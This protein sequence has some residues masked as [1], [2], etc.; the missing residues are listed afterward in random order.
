[1]KLRRYIFVDYYN[2]KLRH[3][4]RL[5]RHYVT[6]WSASVIIMNG[7]IIVFHR[8]YNRV[9]IHI[10]NR[11]RRWLWSVYT[12][13]PSTQCTYNRYSTDINIIDLIIICTYLCIIMTWKNYQ[14]YIYYHVIYIYLLWMFKIFF[15]ISRYVYL[16]LYTWRN[17][18][19]GRLDRKIYIHENKP[20]GQCLWC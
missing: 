16:Y 19:E 1:M 6:W 2:S 18:K 8:V 7:R 20:G 5:M 9:Y 3:W 14:S 10:Y 15:S 12:R 13:D 11:H 4:R 17:K